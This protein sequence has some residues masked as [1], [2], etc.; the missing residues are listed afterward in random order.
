MILCSLSNVK[1]NSFSCE[2]LF[3]DQVERGQTLGEDTDAYSIPLP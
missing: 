2:L 1:K 3:K